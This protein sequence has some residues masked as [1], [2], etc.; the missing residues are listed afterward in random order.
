M[1]KYGI[2]TAMKEEAD[3]IIAKYN[4]EFFTKTQN[5]SFYENDDIVLCLS[6]I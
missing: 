3:I 1:K 6:G 2:I 4:L 5:T